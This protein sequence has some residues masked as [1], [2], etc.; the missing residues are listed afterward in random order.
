[1]ST[2]RFQTLFA[3]AFVLAVSC[4]AA[5]PAYAQSGELTRNFQRGSSLYKAGLAQAALPYMERALELSRLE[6]GPDATRTAFITHN[7]ATLYRT[8]GDNNK[9]EPMFLRALGVLEPA[10]GQ[11]HA[12]VH[13][14]IGELSILLKAQ[15]R[16]ADAIPFLV[17]VLTRAEKTYGE[18]DDRTAAAAYNLAESEQAD[19][20]REA[21]RTHYE[22]ALQIWTGTS[23][24]NDTKLSLVRERL[25][26][27]DRPPPPRNTV[28]LTPPAPINR[29]NPVFLPKTGPWRVQLAA[30]RSEKAAQQAVAKFTAR[31]PELF[32]ATPLTVA[33]GASAGKT[34]YRVK[35]HGLP[36]KPSAQR[37]CA[38][39]KQKRQSC[40]LVRG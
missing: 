39:L 28:T 3:A 1:M 5:G 4:F 23:S 27:L 12:V 20:K 37:L 15:G 10:L 36:D 17:R 13:E 31:F 18:K 8:M 38:E 33:A 30:F 26:E 7:V 22:Q 24:R 34:V 21:A 6:F 11:D 25:T 9:A 19:G 14:I 35:T 40:F 16:H 32:A 2:G 29:P